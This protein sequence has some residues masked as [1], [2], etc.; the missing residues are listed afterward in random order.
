MPQ[1]FP[2]VDLS[3]MNIARPNVGLAIIRQCE[4]AHCVR[5]GKEECVP[6]GCAPVWHAWDQRL[7][8]DPAGQRW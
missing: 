3:N 4:S 2:K 6:A 7:Y 5:L 1:E 8:S